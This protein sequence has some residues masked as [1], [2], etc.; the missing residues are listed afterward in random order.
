M[1]RRS[2]IYFQE[3]RKA[4]AIIAGGGYYMK[5]G[6]YRLHTS[7]TFAERNRER[8][9]HGKREFLEVLSFPLDIE[10]NLKP[11]AEISI[12][13]LRDI[14]KAYLDA[15]E[16]AADSGQEII[17]LKPRTRPE[18]LPNNPFIRAHLHFETLDEAQRYTTTV[19]LIQ[20][21][22]HSYGKHLIE[23]HEWLIPRLPIITFIVTGKS[24]LSAIA[25]P[26]KGFPDFYFKSEFLDQ[27]NE[28]YKKLMQL[29]K[30]AKPKE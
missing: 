22:Q 17:M 29:I 11:K 27:I 20:T 4:K 18:G 19:T 28:S 2:V 3:K 30:E 5:K 1:K 15:F 26:D 13:A 23:Y 21:R 6:K 8:R 25:I 7:Q 16:K 24:T 10:Q 14:D 9:K 12:S